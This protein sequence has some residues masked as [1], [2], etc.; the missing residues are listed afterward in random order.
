MTD[1]WSRLILHQPPEIIHVHM[2]IVQIA[3]FSNSTPATAVLLSPIISGI[4]S[5]PAT[6][7]DHI[8]SNFKVEHSP[9]CGLPGKRMLP[10]SEDF[11]T[12]IMS[13]S[14]GLKMPIHAH[15]F[16]RAILTCKVGQTDLVF[17]CDHGTSVRL[18]TQDCNSLCAAVTICTCTHSVL[19]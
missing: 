4:L 16:R 9:N 13:D 5:A 19:V 17:G 12:S 8:I 6:W 2:H 15:F 7:L 10:I 3:G 18:C 14:A 11:L 1:I